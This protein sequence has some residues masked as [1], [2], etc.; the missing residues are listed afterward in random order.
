M[1]ENTAE[2]PNFVFPIAVVEAIDGDTYKL[3][4]DCGFNTFREI[5]VRLAG[6]DTPEKGE[7]GYHLAKDF[8]YHWL[9]SSTKRFVRTRKTSTGTDR[10]SF[11][12]YVADIYGDNGQQL[13][14]ALV[15]G[16]YAKRV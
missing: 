10:R 13:A 12:R 1:P 8:A 9:A 15:D 2:Q 11:V 5:R 3:L 6:V 7:R 4:V 16:G 14:D